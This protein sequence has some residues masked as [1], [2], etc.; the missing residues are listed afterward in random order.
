MAGRATAAMAARSWMARVP[1]PGSNPALGSSLHAAGYL[2]G[3]IVFMLAQRLSR[4]PLPTGNARIILLA[5]ALLGGTVGAKLSQW[6]ALGLPT[7]DTSLPSPFG[8]GRTVLGGLL[9]GWIAVEIA[10][11]RLGIRYSTGMPFALALT[12]GEAVGRFGC[13]FSGCCGG[14]A[15]NLPWAAAQDGNTVHPSQLYMALGLIAL[16]GLLLWLRTRLAEEGDL[17][18]CYLAGY[19]LLR[20][21]VEATRQQDGLFAGLSLAQWVCLLFIAAGG[22]GLYARTRDRRDN[23]EQHP[24]QSAA[25]ER[26]DG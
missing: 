19:G 1:E 17:F 22:A 4:H 10:K 18:L 8:G 6:L 9:V 12:A 24:L 20:F 2:V 21:T 7:G 13:W 3:S 11:S 25:G 26:A 14:R 5:A 15:C 16:L 23:L